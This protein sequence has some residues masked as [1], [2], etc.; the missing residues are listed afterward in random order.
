MRHSAVECDSDDSPLC[1]FHWR[2]V[3]PAPH[4]AVAAHRRASRFCGMT[5]GR[6]RC[7]R[8]LPTRVYRTSDQHKRPS[9]A[10]RAASHRCLSVASSH[11]PYDFSA[12]ERKWRQRWAETA[13]QPAQQSHDSG[14]RVSQPPHTASRDTRAHSTATRLDCSTD[15]GAVHCAAAVGCVV[16]SLRSTLCPCFLTRPARC[17]WVTCGCTAS[18]TA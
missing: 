8:P 15:R 3:R 17:T 6:L 7:L 5:V 1:N 13:N 16:A 11:A 2:G 10:G 9:T 4:V 14:N 12:V 18:A